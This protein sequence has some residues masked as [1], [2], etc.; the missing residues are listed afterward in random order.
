MRWLDGITDFMNMSLSELRELVMDRPQGGTPCYFSDFILECFSHHSL[1]SSHVDLYAA[2]HASQGHS[3]FSAFPFAI[4]SAW[5]F[6][7]F[8]FFFLKHAPPTPFGYFLKCYFLRDYPWGSQ[9]ALAVK[10]PPANA[11]NGK[12]H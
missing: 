8:R 4:L 1:H 10:N 3:L 11:G 5:I 9:V 7:S 12:R 6:F 2:F